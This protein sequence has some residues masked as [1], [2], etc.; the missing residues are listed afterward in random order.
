MHMKLE[1]K[2]NTYN[3]FFFFK[4]RITYKLSVLFKDKIKSRMILNFAKTLYIC[5]SSQI[6]LCL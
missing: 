1:I 4:V 3:F 5:L 6:A 2:L